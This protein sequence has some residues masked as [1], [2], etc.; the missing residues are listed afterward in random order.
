MWNALTVEAQAHNEANRLKQFYIR[1]EAWSDVYITLKTWI[2]A[3]EPALSHALGYL[4]GSEVRGVVTAT[5]KL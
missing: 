3:H 2:A 4:C 1:M 5:Y